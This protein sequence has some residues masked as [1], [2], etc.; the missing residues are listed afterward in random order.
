MTRQLLILSA[1][2]LPSAGLVSG[3]DR[4]QASA[5]EGKAQA[6]DHD[7]VHDHAREGG[8]GGGGAVAAA[9]NRIDLPARV[10][11]NLGITFAK[12]E[13]RRV[14]ATVRLPGRFELLPTARREARAVLP[15][16]VDLLVRQYDAVTA[17]QVLARLDSPEWR[18]VQHEAVEA[19]GEIKTAEAHVDVAEATR[20][21][22]ASA[23]ALLA[24]RVAAL[25]EANARRADL[26]V[27]LALARG[28]AARLDAEVRAAKVKLDEAREHYA[29]KLRTLASVVGLPPERLIEP[30]PATGPTAGP[31]V[32]GGGREPF[33][34]TIGSVDI[35][36]SHAG[37][38]ESLAITGG[39]WAEAG[40]LL[41]TTVDPAQ[42]RFR[43]AGLQSDLSRLREGAAVSI[44]PPASVGGGGAALAIPG[45]LAVGLEASADSRTF[46]LIVT[47]EAGRIAPW[48][49]AG[50][51]AYA[52]VVTDDSVDREPAIPVAAVV[53]DELAKVY[54][55]RDPKDPDKVIRV[56]GDFGVSDGKW[57]VVASGLKK[58][59]EVVLDGV[60][61]LKLTGGGKS[62]GKGHFHA[63]G[64]WHEA[65]TP[66]PGGKK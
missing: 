44:V 18:R 16:R 35:R 23:I 6:D 43:A 32:A 26:D 47:P 45:K 7:H 20:G 1:L 15:G 42:I 56:E 65:G 66:E 50:V 10:R 27:E 61:E 63:D 4:R 3:C 12:V 13:Q 57:V 34:R 36:S 41:L 21:E 38:V 51:S 14:A 64:T 54:F 40:G 31:A 11:E 30:A 55:R 49:R 24:G 19:E 62:Q 22:N 17:G 58:G 37:V 33:W 48:A 52:E 25:A 2:L 28:K 60:Y 8:G 53:Q 9:T 59:D 39:G 46:D 29:S 5:G